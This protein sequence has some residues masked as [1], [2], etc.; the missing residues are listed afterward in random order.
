MRL[1]DLTAIAILT[2]VAA[3]P[4]CASSNSDKLVSIIHNAGQQVSTATL[5]RAMVQLMQ[6]RDANTA[7]DRQLSRKPSSACA[8]T[9]AMPENCLA[10]LAPAAGP[11]ATSRKH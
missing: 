9:A 8:Q 11:A 2:I 5:N 4:A 10:L 3:Q 6:A 7:G 1:K